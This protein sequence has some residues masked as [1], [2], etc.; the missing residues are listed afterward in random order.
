MK[1]TGGIAKTKRTLIWLIAAGLAVLFIGIGTVLARSGSTSGWPA[2]KALI[3]EQQQ[4]AIADARSHPRPKLPGAGM[5]AAAQTP[6]RRQAGIVAMRQ[7]PFPPSTFLVRNFWQ[8]PVGSDWI[9][10][11]AGAAPSSPGGPFT[12]GALRIYRETAD[13]QLSEIGSY[14]AAPGVGP[15]TITAANGD[16]LQLRSDNGGVLSFNLQTRQY[17]Q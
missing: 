3:A 9:L 16:E 6:P 11:Y 12:R 8:G 14:P 10:V 15:V 13:L 1:T 17:H 5:S 7:G 2:A 4:Q